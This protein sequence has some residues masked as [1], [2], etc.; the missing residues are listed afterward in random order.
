[1][2]GKDAD[3]G[4]V[5]KQL[6]SSLPL[7]KIV[8]SAIGSASLGPGMGDVNDIAIQISGLVDPI[9]PRK[10]CPIA[11]CR[12]D[13]KGSLGYLIRGYSTTGYS[14]GAGSRRTYL[15][16]LR[17][18]RLGSQRS[19]IEIVSIPDA[20]LLGKW[21]A[22]HCAAIQGYRRIPATCISDLGDCI[23]NSESPRILQ[24]AIRVTLKSKGACG[25]KAIIGVGALP[26]DSDCLFVAAADRTGR[27]RQSPVGDSKGNDGLRHS[28]HPLLRIPHVFVVKLGAH[29][30]GDTA[31]RN[32]HNHENQRNFDQAETALS[33][34]D[35]CPQKNR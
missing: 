7:Q 10:L 30:S 8:K 25:N 6:G 18:S 34:L 20:V 33:R 4:H 21:K 15:L 1:M 19:S 2:S 32:P 22:G 26:Y 12:P 28:A 3:S 11:P 16:K 14:S 13:H 17:D 29:R 27:A 24:Q 35:R 9:A 5:Q 31:Q 23:P